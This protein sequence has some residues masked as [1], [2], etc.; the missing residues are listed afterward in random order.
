MNIQSIRLV[1]GTTPTEGRVEVSINGIW[2]TVCDDFWDNNDATV[3][4]RQLG[5]VY[6]PSEALLRIHDV[7]E[8]GSGFIWLDDVTCQ[9]SEPRLEDCA[10]TPIGQTNCRHSEDAGVR[11][12]GGKGKDL[13]LLSKQEI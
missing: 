1:G 6:G 12:V 2:G 9:G 3:V 7:F 4:C 8:E 13:I 10:Q 5:H 11:C